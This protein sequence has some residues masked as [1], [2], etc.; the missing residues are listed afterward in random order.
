MIINH[1][2]HDHLCHH[3][4][5]PHNQ[6]SK[7]ILIVN[8]RVICQSSGLFIC[9]LQLPSAYCRFRSRTGKM[10]SE[11]RHQACAGWPSARQKCGASDPEVKCP[12]A[13]A[14]GMLETFKLW[15][16]CR[17]QGG[18]LHKLLRA[19]VEPSCILGRHDQKR[20][21]IVHSQDEHERFWAGHAIHFLPAAGLA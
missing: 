13:R 11:V 19:S 10:S 20:C 14:L 18:M 1:H 21:H 9:A 16:Q 15:A 6:A 2:E 5:Q 7:M 12:K 4:H 8:P 3:N 17:P